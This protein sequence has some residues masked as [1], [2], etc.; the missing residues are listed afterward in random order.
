MKNNLKTYEALGLHF[1]LKLLVTAVCMYVV[2]IN[3]N[4]DANI[5]YSYPFVSMQVKDWGPE[6]RPFEVH[7]EYSPNCEY[8]SNNGGDSGDNHPLAS[9]G[10][11]GELTD[12]Y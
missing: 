9:R 2:I 10:A 3:L 8:I 7:R 4:A 1:Q 6:N 11:A 12:I 5:Q